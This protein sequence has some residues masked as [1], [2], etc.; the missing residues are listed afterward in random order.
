[1]DF[2][3]TVQKLEVVLEQ[4]GGGKCGVIKVGFPEKV[5]FNPRYKGDEEPSQEKEHPDRGEKTASTKA[6][7]WDVAEVFKEQ[8]SHGG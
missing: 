7:W 6:Q 3:Q 2:L 8:G 4:E 1:M 5:T